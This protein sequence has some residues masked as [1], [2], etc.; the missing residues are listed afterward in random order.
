MRAIIFLLLIFFAVPSFG[1]TRFRVI[2]KA[3]GKETNSWTSDFAD[4]NYYEPAFGKPGEYNLVQ[5]DITQQVADTAAKK[6]ASEVR[7]ARLKELARK[8]KAGTDVAADRVEA[9]KLMMI[10]I[11]KDE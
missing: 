9:L 3:T 1:L 8:F 7:I 10:E 5:E 6:T 4:Q 2:N 11:I